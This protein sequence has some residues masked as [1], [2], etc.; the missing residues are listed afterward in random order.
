[1]KASLGE[2]T[3]TPSISTTETLETLMSET[4]TEQDAAAEK[5]GN[6]AIPA[7]PLPP[8]QHWGWE[9]FDD[10]QQALNWLN[11]PPVQSA[12]EVSAM[13][14]NDGTGTIRIFFIQPPTTPLLPS[15]HWLFKSFSNPAAAVNYLNKPPAQSDGEVS[16]I[17]QNDNTIGVFYIGPA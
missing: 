9:D 1:M 11:T 7:V 6:H 10:P 17:Y 5:A 4:I 8:S 14:L 13:A 3:E 12:G 16:A 2:W 15:Q